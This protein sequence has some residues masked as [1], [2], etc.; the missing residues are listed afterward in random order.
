LNEIW[1]TLRFQP[2]LPC[3]GVFGAY[4]WIQQKLF[5]VE[6][7]AIFPLTPMLTGVLSHLFTPLGLL[8]LHPT[9]K[10]NW[11]HGL[12]GLPPELVFRENQKHSWSDFWWV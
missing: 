12:V 5:R 6:I 3:K 1:Q 4:K 8:S 11:L 2:V 7:F 10:K 9:G